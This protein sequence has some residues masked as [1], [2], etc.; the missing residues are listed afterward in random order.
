MKHLRILPRARW[1][2]VDGNMGSAER[3]WGTGLRCRIPIHPGT[4]PAMPARSADRRTSM[5]VRSD[6]EKVDRKSP[7]RWAPMRRTRA[8]LLRTMGSALLA[9]MTVGSEAQVSTVTLRCLSGYRDLGVAPRAVDLV[10]GD[11]V[12]FRLSHDGVNPQYRWFRDG[13]AVVGTTNRNWEIAAVGT[14]A[15]GDYSAVVAAGGN[16]VT[17]AI[18]AL[19]VWARPSVTQTPPDLVQASSALTVSVAPLD[20]PGAGGFQW[21]RDAQAIAGETNLTLTRPALRMT[22]AG[23]YHFEAFSSILNRRV[24][25]R[26]HQVR[27]YS[28]LSPPAIV[29]QPAD[30]VGVAGGSAVFT[31]G[32]SGTPPFS[33][34]WFRRGVPLAEG[35]NFFLR[36]SKLAPEDEGGYWVEVLG[37]SGAVTSRVARL[38]LTVPKTPNPTALSLVTSGR[39]ALGQHTNTSLSAAVATFEAALL[40]D[41]ENDLASFFLGI[42][43]V[44]NVVNEAPANA[45]LDRL[46]FGTEGRNLYDW[47]SEPPV[48]GTGRWLAP[49]QVGSAEGPQFAREELLPTIQN[50]LTNLA[51]PIL[52]DFAVELTSAETTL[53]GVIVDQGDLW[54]VRAL[55]YA[56]GYGI[57]TARSLDLSSS[58]SAVEALATSGLLT[59]E[60]FLDDHPGF[61]TF[62]G[63]NE[64]ATARAELESAI[65]AYVQAAGIIRSRPH[66]LVRMFTLDAV[67]LE[68]E[69]RFRQGL[70]DLKASLDQLITVNE[71]PQFL[72]RY[73]RLA[74]GSVVPRDL[75][76][77]F[78]DNQPGVLPDPGLGGIV[79]SV[80]APYIVQHPATVY[81]LP[82]EAVE[83]GVSALGAAGLRYQWFKDGS[84]VVGASGRRLRFPRPATSVDGEYRVLVSNEIG[85]IWSE[86]A[87]VTPAGGVA[88]V[89][90]GE[91][92]LT[93]VPAG[94]TDI[95]QIA[96]GRSHLV[97]LRANGRV[98]SWGS[99][100]VTNVPWGLSG[101]RWVAANNWT[102]FALKADGTVVAWGQD[103]HRYPQNLRGIRLLDAWEASMAV[104]DEVGRITLGSSSGS[105]LTHPGFNDIQSLSIWNG[106]V[107]AVRGTGELVGLDMTTGGLVPD[108]AEFRSV[109]SAS[110]AW[111]WGRQ[112]LL[113]IRRDGTVG[114]VHPSD[115]RDETVE[116]GGVVRGSGGLFLRG[117]GSVWVLPGHYR[118]AQLRPIMEAVSGV[119][120]VAGDSATAAIVGTA[121]LFGVV[122]A[123]A[124]EGGAAAFEVSAVGVAPFAYQWMFNGAP[125]PGATEPRLIMT[126]VQPAAA[127]NYSVRVGS[128]IGAVTSRTAKLEVNT[129]ADRFATPRVIVPGG[130]R[131]LGANGRATREPGEPLHAGNMGGHSLWFAWTPSTGGS[132]RIDTIGSGFDT[133]LA[134]YTGDGLENLVLVAADDDGAGAAGA[135]QVTFDAQAGVTYRIA[136][137]GYNGAV[138]MVT[139][140]VAPVF[141]LAGLHF[142]PQ[143]GFGFEALGQSGRTFVIESSFDLR[144]WTP[145]LTNRLPDLGTAP[146]REGHSLDPP[147]RFFR[148]VME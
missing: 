31:V 70:L 6:R 119:S 46:R 48:D 4:A 33:Y 129:A 90:G 18:I 20:L 71:A 64:M 32:A 111:V 61:L 65:D 25:S 108:Y 121:F 36:L 59:I 94:L 117:D 42:T 148:A 99:G 140:N 134:V 84:E 54:L 50:A 82:G 47:T 74:D 131:Y 136:V 118:Y 17:S 43:R 87:R 142:E 141:R 75:L 66:D 49:P 124:D 135:S 113:A 143:E 14:A 83:L 27:V 114:W 120:S 144:K 104:V 130:G 78:S 105:T 10:E 1:R 37:W 39:A 41:P 110:R 89:I 57:R 22:E 19:K 13:L 52:N 8:A 115:R 51:V 3:C 122:D 126:N 73:G 35:T 96:V 9:A 63:T 21:Y 100:G 92:S 139:L 97:A 77:A 86:A 133:L 95:V 103:A 137:D 106:S 23:R 107:L 123:V 16:A 76:P 101:V 29:T 127:G 72:L 93:N 132:T 102:S 138:G 2:I 145:I 81:Y 53:E 30:Q 98:V 11:P 91:A 85:S 38:A 112:E 56:A 147:R 26:P 79:G 125:I 62:T 60:R 116:V 7:R 146:F 12:S 55:G 58:L 128:A 15:T 5:I 69:T 44:L 40:L 80:G 24:A 28:F 109:A 45:F 34:R 88:M 68:G 67:D